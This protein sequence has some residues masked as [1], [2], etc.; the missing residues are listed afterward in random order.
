MYM[1]ICIYVKIMYKYIY[2]DR[3][4]DLTKIEIPHTSCR[5]TFFEHVLKVSDVNACACQNHKGCM[6]A[7][8]RFSSSYS[9]QNSV[10]LLPDNS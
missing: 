5:Q 4:M 9:L 1:Y 3:Y 8:R 2:R 10:L 7:S 6:F